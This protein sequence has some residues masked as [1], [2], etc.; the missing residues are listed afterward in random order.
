MYSMVALTRPGNSQPLGRVRVYQKGGMGVQKALAVCL[1]ALLFSGC[2][3]K[4]I[5]PHII[6]T[7]D[8]GSPPPPDHQ[9]LTMTHL[10]ARL[11]APVMALA[12]EATHNAAFCARVGGTTEVR[13]TSRLPWREQLRPGGLRGG[14]HRV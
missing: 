14:R 12:N 9:A 8:Y 3:P 2:A 5:P 7:A 6:A 11:I 1:V 13:H 4:A 10:G